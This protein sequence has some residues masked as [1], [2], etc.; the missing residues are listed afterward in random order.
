MLSVSFMALY[1]PGYLLSLVVF[2]RRGLRYGLC[3]AAL[4]QTAGAWTRVMGTIGAS[5]DHAV[6][7][8]GFLIVFIGQCMAAMAQ[9]MFMKSVQLQRR[10]R[11]AAQRQHNTAAEHWAPLHLQRLDS[12]ALHCIEC[13]P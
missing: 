9:P 3:L 13:L 2:S 1:L 8:R 5:D 6:H 4:L 7:T 10:A 12:D 11:S